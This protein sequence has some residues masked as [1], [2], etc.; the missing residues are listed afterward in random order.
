MGHDVKLL[1]VRFI[2]PFV[3]N[4]KTDA[5]DAKVGWT[6]ADQPDMRTVSVKTEEQQAI[7][8]LHRIRLNLVKSRTAQ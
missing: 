8:A 3:Q 5:A 4:N 2:R 7:L 1:H 6:A